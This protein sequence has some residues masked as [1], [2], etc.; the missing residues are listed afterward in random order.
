MPTSRLT[1]LGYELGLIS[2]QRYQAFLQKQEA[3][4]NELR[5]LRK[6]SIPC[7]ARPQREA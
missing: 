3:I 4:S 7:L 5:R 6:T 1:P 2:P